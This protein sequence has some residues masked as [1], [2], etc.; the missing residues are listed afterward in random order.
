MTVLSINGEQRKVSASPDSPLLYV[1]RG[2][3]RMD[4]PA[5]I[6]SLQLERRRRARA[7][8]NFQTASYVSTEQRNLPPP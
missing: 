2:E 1:L 7:A 5:V 6:E 3:L 8:Y 4:V